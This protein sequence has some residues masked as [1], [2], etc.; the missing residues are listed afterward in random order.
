MT[1]RQQK[2][3]RDVRDLPGIKQREIETCVRCCKGVGHSGGLMFYRVGIERFVIDP[4]AVQRAHGLEQLL[5]GNAHLAQVMGPD[6]DIA[7]QVWRHEF[8][9]CDDCAMTACVAELDE[10]AAVVSEIADE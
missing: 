5:G 1:D 6:E 4:G 8:L 10:C 9:L 7:K 3:S 2:A